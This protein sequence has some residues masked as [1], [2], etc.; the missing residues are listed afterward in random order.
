V[1]ESKE[2]IPSRLRYHIHV[3]GDL[4]G[5]TIANQYDQ[6]LV[7]T[8]EKVR[9]LSKSRRQSDPQLKTELLRALKGLQEQELTAVTRA[10]NQFLQLSNIAEQVQ[11]LSGKD[12][13]S[14]SE[15]LLENMFQTLLTAGKSPDEISAT[16]FK[17]KCDLVLTAHP[18]QIT[19]RTLIQKYDSIAN[20]LQSL[21]SGNPD[22]ESLKS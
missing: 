4:L 6:G 10:F 13:S 18:T 16:I 19:R 3:L 17:L 5:E 22:Q 2:H 11:T 20:V 12:P 8:V 15:T 14:A 1:A 7:D 9:K 21:E